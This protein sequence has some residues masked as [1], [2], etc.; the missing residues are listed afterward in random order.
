MW[1]SAPR[2]LLSL[3]CLHF[4]VHQ[5]VHY[6]RFIFGFMFLLVRFCIHL[7][8]QVSFREHP[9][10][11]D[12]YALIWNLCYIIESYL[13]LSFV[14]P[15]RLLTAPCTTIYIIVFI[16]YGAGIVLYACVK[17]RV[18]YILKLDKFLIFQNRTIKLLA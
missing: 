9:Q 10:V 1:S 2:T 5:Q 3:F 12:M 15:N 7:H 14:V 11:R 6:K 18:N 8:S 13:W 16:I 4:L 17:K